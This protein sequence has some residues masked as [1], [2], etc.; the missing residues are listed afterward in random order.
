MI[1]IQKKIQLKKKTLFF[2]FKCGF[3]FIQNSDW[4]EHIKIQAIVEIEEDIDRHNNE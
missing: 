1:E 4:R 2:S 3:L